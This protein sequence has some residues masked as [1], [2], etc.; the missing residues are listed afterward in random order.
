MIIKRV[1][2]ESG[3][4]RHLQV[5][6][7]LCLGCAPDRIEQR[8]KRLG[9]DAYEVRKRSHLVKDAQPTK[10]L[11]AKSRPGKRLFW[12]VCV[13][14]PAKVR[15]VYEVQLPLHRLRVRRTTSYK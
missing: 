13:Y 8:I 4:N 3:K 14:L 5:P 10:E 12:D 2:S 9:A 6:R 7:H 11:A 1:R 15:G